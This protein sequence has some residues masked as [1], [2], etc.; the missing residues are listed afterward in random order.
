MNLCIFCDTSPDAYGFVV[1]GVQ[2]TKSSML[3]SKAK[4]APMKSKIPPTLEL[5]GV[6]L[7]VKCLPT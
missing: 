3:F 6:Y 4:L 1:Y 7:A 2:N 5:L